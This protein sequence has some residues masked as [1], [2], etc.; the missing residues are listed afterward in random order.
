M[1]TENFQMN[2]HNSVTKNSQKSETTQVANNWRRNI[3]K[4][5]CPNNGIQFSNKKGWD[6][7]I[8]SN[9][10]ELQKYYAKWKM[11]D[12]A[13]D[14]ILYNLIWNIEKLNPWDRTKIMVTWGWG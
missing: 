7:E 9:M 1:P 2:A 14:H 13:Y 5:V 8:C 10:D 11:L 4:V 12:N 3:Q 6:T